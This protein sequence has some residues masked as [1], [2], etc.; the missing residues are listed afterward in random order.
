[1]FW[2]MLEMGIAIVAIRLPVL[3][4]LHR[5]WST[6]DLLVRLRLSIF[7]KAQHPP[8]RSSGMEMVDVNKARRQV[9][10][11]PKTSADHTE[12]TQTSEMV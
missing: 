4:G 10:H 3:Y 6:R 2:D 1:M 5:H 7:G 11:T 12:I 8:S 9:D